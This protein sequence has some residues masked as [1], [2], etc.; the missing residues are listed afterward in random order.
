MIAIQEK[1]PEIQKTKTFSP[2]VS[3]IIPAYNVAEYIVET[4]DSA[5][6][7]T[8]LDHEIIVI[9][10]GSP[11]TEKF[12]KAI[13]PYREKIIY[14]KQPN[15][16]AAAARNAGIEAA[17]GEM[18]A[19]LDGDDVWLPDYLE[20][21][22]SFLQATGGDMVYCDAILFGNENKY[23]T[24]MALSPSRGEVT[25]ESL[26]SGTCNVITSGTVVLRGTVLAGGMFDEKAPLRIE[27]FDL[28]FRLLKNG[29]RVDYQKNILLKYRIRPGSL[30][31]SNI[32]RVERS[33]TALKEVKRKHALTPA[34]DA[35]WHKQFKKAEQELAV[36]KGKMSLIGQ[37]YRRALAHF[38]D[39][40][41]HHRTI[42]LSLIAALTKFSPQ[43]AH[44]LF[45]NFR[46]GEAGSFTANKK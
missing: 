2:K 34:E 39:A 5:L 16:G 37:D 29:A 38:Q 9:N 22:I 18:L 41:R 13:A 7:Q 36:Q 21:Q 28:W 33:I 10:D 31:G 30:S 25:A 27:D 11:D 19:F 14:L 1:S 3:V 26:L 43:T 4:L 20:Q 17:R 23:K 12:E 15:K 24:Y 42:K 35:A 46:A 6:A 32:E 40:N 8:F 44:W 45:R